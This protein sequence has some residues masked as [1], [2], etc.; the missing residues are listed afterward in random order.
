ERAAVRAGAHEVEGGM[1]AA[2]GRGAAERQVEGRAFRA[3]LLLDLDADRRIHALQMR[4][5]ADDEVDACRLDPRIVERCARGGRAELGQYRQR[6]VVA[7]RD[8]R[9]HAV[10]VENAVGRVD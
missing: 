3:D 8:A 2:G 7:R 4:R 6:V 1:E 9:G 10:D 5:G